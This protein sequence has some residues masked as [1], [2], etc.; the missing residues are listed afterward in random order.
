M[1]AAGIQFSALMKQRRFAE[2]AAFAD[3]LVV[4]SGGHSVFWLTRLSASYSL[5]GNHAEALAAAGRAR[6]LDPDDPWVLL[7]YGE[8]LFRKGSFTEAYPFLADAAANERTA[9]R[10]RRYALE[11][12]V[13][14]RQWASLLEHLSRWEL[15]AEQRP[16]WRAK[17]LAGLGQV[18]EALEECRLWL[19]ASPDN[20]DALWVQAELQIT[21]EGLD[22]VIATM[23]RLAKIPGKPPVYGEIYAA[24]CRRGGRASEA[25]RQYQRMLGKQNTPA[26]QRK[27]V[28]ALAKAGQESDSLPLFEELLRSAPADLYLNNGYIG[29]ASRSNNLER[30]WTFYH[31]LSAL[32]PEEKTILGRLRKVRTAMERCNR[33]AASQSDSNRESVE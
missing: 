19:E 11:C 18:D 7:A 9:Q 26:L 6:A 15:N 16:P 10:A 14:T 22:A 21:R 27:K 25:L 31:E 33:T 8:A 24:L 2:C 20:R 23:S 32:H 12:L 17:A 29:A 5:V 30:C 1:N 4:E 3:R 28:F 13:R